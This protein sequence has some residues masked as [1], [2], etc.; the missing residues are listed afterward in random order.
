MRN[1]RYV[2]SVRDW[3]A[4][5]TSETLAFVAHGDPVETA[6]EKITLDYVRKNVTKDEKWMNYLWRSFLVRPAVTAAFE[7]ASKTKPHTH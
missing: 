2:R 6:L 7:Q 4:R 1:T 5:I 3:L